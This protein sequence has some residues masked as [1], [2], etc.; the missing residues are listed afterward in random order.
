MFV[1]FQTWHRWDPRDPEVGEWDA[2]RDVASSYE[3]YRLS[4]LC[5]DGGSPPYR[6]DLSHYSTVPT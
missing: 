3:A 2:F 1:V 4:C 5:L 6:S